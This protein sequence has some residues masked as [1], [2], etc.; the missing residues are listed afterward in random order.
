MPETGTPYARYSRVT[1]RRGSLRPLNCPL[2]P[3]LMVAEFSG[4]LPPDVAQAVREHI[5]TCEICGARA[6]ALRTPY[7]LLTSLGAEPVPYVPDLRERVR[8]KAASEERW[9]G[10]LRA[11]GSAGRFGFLSVVLGLVVVGVLAYLLRGGLLGL[12]AF[13]TSRTTNA[14]AHVAPAAPS[15]MLLAETN[16]V[17][18]VS[19]NDGQ[20]WQVAETLVTDQRTGRV[21]R[22]IPSVDTSLSVGSASSLPIDIASDGHVVYELT[23]AQNGDRQALVAINVASGATRFITPLTMP[24]G[25]ALPADAHALSLTISPDGQSIYVSIGG[26][27]GKLL[28]VRM[29][30][31]SVSGKVMAAF[32]PATVQETALPAPAGSL[33]ST[34]FPSQTPIV[35]LSGMTFS[36]AARG[37]VEISPD[38]QWL[39]DALFASDAHGGRYLVVRRISVTNGQTV[40]AI[41]LTGAFHSERLAVS[42]NINSEQLYLVSGSPD[43]MVYVFDTTSA[44][45]T[46]T[47]DIALGGPT[48]TNGAGLGDGLYI[49]PTVDGQRLYVTEDAVSTDGSVTA[50]TRWLV[51]T[52][53]MTVLG[54]DSELTTVGAILANSSTSPQAKVFALVDGQIQVNAPD[55]SAAWSPWLRGSDNTPVLRLIASHP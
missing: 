23:S 17:L 53:G 10:P 8:S 47:G 12:G 40:Q 5:A 18:T 30:V 39:F 45:P 3:E 24:N 25:A 2:E 43:A 13:T 36:E 1:T 49:S 55:F 50:H 28:S 27:N 26:A 11:I 4:E 51:D 33:P 20:S 6:V 38:G 19:G 7:N 9:L 31:V 52:Q 41:G 34:A 35:D 37:A 46:L 42:S 22:S 32:N 29:L 21:T 15:G 16:K 54:S 14:L 44:G 48:T